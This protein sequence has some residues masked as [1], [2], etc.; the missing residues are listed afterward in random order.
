MDSLSD[1]PLFP[2]NTVLFPGMVLPL[3]IFEA[4]YKTMINHCLEE[5]QPFGVVLIH[6]GNEVGGGAVPYHV[7]TTAIIA[8]V[9]R[10]AEGRL[11]IATI[12]SQR[13]RLREIHPEQPY[14][15]GN[16]EPWPLAGED[17]DRARALVGPVR[18]LFLQYLE[19]LQEAQGDK[20]SVE[21]ISD[22]PRALGLLAAIALQLPLPQKQ[23][24]LEQSTVAELLE[25]ELG[26]LRREQAL[27]QHI[28]RTQDDQWEGGYSGF[29]AKN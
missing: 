23:S 27:L 22:E 18:S 13:F 21:E 6:E 8:G 20:I 1:L 19:L 26:L 17:S 10:L 11:N 16:A 7:G 2:L 15:V 5:E 3:H 12:G 14:L 28:K 9:S 24:L 25:A 4:R 29:L